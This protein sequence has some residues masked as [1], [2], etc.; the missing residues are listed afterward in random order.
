MS[1]V[2]QSTKFIWFVGWKGLNI[3]LRLLDA[4]FADQVV[5]RLARLVIFTFENYKFFWKLNHHNHILTNWL[6]SFDQLT[7]F[8]HHWGGAGSSSSQL[9]HPCWKNVDNLLVLILSLSLKRLMALGK[10]RH[11]LYN[12]KAFFIILGTIIWN[13]FQIYRIYSQT[14]NT[15]CSLFF[16]FCINLKP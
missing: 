14:A 11:F 2:G 12:K 10:I 13:I 3:I 5:G 15:L 9:S 16:S 8:F 7:Y 4:H 6:L 1:F